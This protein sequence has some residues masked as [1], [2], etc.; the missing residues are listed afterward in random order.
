MIHGLIIIFVIVIVILAIIT[1]LYYPN[2]IKIHNISLENTGNNMTLVFVSDFEMQSNENVNK[3]IDKINQIDPDVVLLGGDY[4]VYEPL[5]NLKSKNIYGVLG[6]A[7]Y[8]INSILGNDPDF[9]HAKQMTEKMNFKVLRNKNVTIDDVVIVGLDVYADKKN[10]T[11]L[12]SHI[13]DTDKFIIVLAHTQRNFIPNDTRIDLTLLGHT[14]GYTEIPF[15]GKVLLEFLQY[16][17]DSDNLYTTSGVAAPRLQPNEIVVIQLQNI[18]G[19]KP[20]YLE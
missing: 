2:Q 10:T 18:W 7:E 20:S 13:P 5:K 6:N 11:K 19:I 1:F 12:N 8:K 16:L 15:F 14:H 4:E 9:S 3:V 17:P